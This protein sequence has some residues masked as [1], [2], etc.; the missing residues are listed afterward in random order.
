[1]A[2]GFCFFLGGVI[3]LDI[4]YGIMYVFFL[5][6]KNRYNKKT[7]QTFSRSFSLGQSLRDY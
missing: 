7:Q 6:K 4:T 2:F 3:G 1:V 5:L